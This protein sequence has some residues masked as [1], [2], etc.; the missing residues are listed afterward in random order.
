LTL[1]LFKSALNTST[2]RPF[3]LDVRQQIQVAAEAGYDGIE[4]W[5][6]DIEAYVNNGGTMKELRA[7]LAD[8]GVALINAI[9]FIKWAD[10]DE[11]VRKAAMKQAEREMSMLAELGCAGIAMPPFGH[12]EG[13]T[14]DA[15]AVHFAGMLELGRKLGI[16]PILEF[17]GRAKQL[18]RLSEA[19]Y[20]AMETGMPDVKILIDPFH[21][22]TGGSDVNSL[23][24]LDGRRI[25]VVHVNDY[26]ANPPQET[27]ADR[28]RVFP[29]DGVAPSVKFAELLAQN[30][31]RGYLSLELFMDNYGAKSAV[32]VAVGGLEKIKKAYQTP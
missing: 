2:L 30:G 31:Y 24:Y 6:K 27:I 7:I 15:M 8:S 26:P 5:M 18:S 20:V 32:E 10:S 16:E 11:E 23:S 28:D 12:V 4:L 1:F 19:V 14:M 21:M 25:G 3:Q 13:V 17:W 22:Y 9:A 29:G